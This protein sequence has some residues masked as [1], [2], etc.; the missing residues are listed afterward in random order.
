MYFPLRVLGLNYIMYLPEVSA[1]RLT[2]PLMRTM[3]KVSN[4]SQDLRM[5]SGTWEID[6]SSSAYYSITFVF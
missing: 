6:T 5:V 4:N 1:L 3:L 2:L